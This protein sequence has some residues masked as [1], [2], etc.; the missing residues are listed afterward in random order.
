MNKTQ[1]KDSMWLISQE[2]NELSKKETM[3]DKG[4]AIKNFCKFFND[5]MLLL[6]SLDTINC[7]SAKRK[8]DLV[9][10]ELQVAFWHFKKNLSV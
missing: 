5:K 10:Y 4:S 6:N 3:S 7:P 8:Y 9:T 2:L 1:I